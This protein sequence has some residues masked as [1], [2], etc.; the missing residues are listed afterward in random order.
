MLALLDFSVILVVP[1]FI[2]R[3]IVIGV[4]AFLA[5]LLL[6]GFGARPPVVFL[7]PLWSFFVIGPTLSIAMGVV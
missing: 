6:R 7:K 1:L 3:L 4:F 5:F 2:L